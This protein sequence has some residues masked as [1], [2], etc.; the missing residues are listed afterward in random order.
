MVKDVYKNLG[1]KPKQNQ[2]SLFS[3]VILL[4]ILS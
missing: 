2:F 1:L 4:N 3:A